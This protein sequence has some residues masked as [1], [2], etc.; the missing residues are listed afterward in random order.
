MDI[1]Y[2]SLLSLFVVVFSCSLRFGFFK[3]KLDV[4]VKPPPG[5]RGWPVIGETIEFVTCGRKGHPEKFIVDRM[6]KF[7]RHVFRTSLMLED[8]AVFCGPEGNKF[9]FSNDNKLV[10]FWVPAS[11]KK[12]IPSL[13][14]VNQTV[15]KTVRN[16]LKP[17][18]LREYVPI[19]DMVAQ[20]HFET[21]W[22]GNGQIL[23]HKLTKNF[24]F[25]VAC[26]IFFGVDEP[27]WVNKLSVPFERLAPGLFSIPLNLPGTLFRRA[28]NAGAFINKELTA[29]VKK[30]KSDLADG[31]ASPTQDILSLLLCDDYG[32]LMQETE[33]AD[34]IMGLMIGGY[35][36]TSSTCT[37]I[38]K[39]LAELPE[40]Y[41]GVYKEQIEI[42]KYKK[43]TELLNWEDLSK[44]KYSWNVA[45]EVLRLVPPTQGTFR[46]AI[47]DFT[48][49]GYS[50]PKGWKL[51]WSTN[52][53]HKNPDFFPEPKKFDP[54]R[55]DSKVP[56]TPYTYVPF[57]GGA[58][59][60]PGKEFARLEILVFI[61]HLVRR[62]KLKKVIRNEDVIFNLVQPEV[63]KGLP[64]HLHP[65]KPKN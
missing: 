59:L 31:K 5:G 22:E 39:Y 53:T 2:A 10:Q 23:T 43:S 13:K 44:M 27:E 14:G 56:I 30:R 62:F 4:D 7:S 38:V 52:S 18:T 50:I 57:G 34:A 12:I 1:F 28:L 49:K 26:K 54:S 15:L 9:L 45:C 47:S 55:F 6:T 16:I 46:E 8:A 20:K 25:L 24:T 51:Y 35:D 37:F 42:A 61:H 60:C 36:S 17:E 63:A 29:I 21:G 64:I 40:I 19:M 48:Y 58:H 11:V 65:H 41:E 32:R 33:V 3:S